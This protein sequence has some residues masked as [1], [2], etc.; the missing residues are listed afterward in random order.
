ML[1]YL[2][3]HTRYGDDGYEDTKLIGVY[4]TNERAQKT[5]DAYM[6]LPGFREHPQGF[7][8]DEYKLDKD[9]WCEG[10]GEPV[11]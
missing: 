11:Q 7:S 4:S 8:I 1:V 3:H 2:L 10:F 5:L 9:T 6:A